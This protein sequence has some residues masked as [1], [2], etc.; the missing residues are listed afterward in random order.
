MDKCTY[1]S[2]KRIGVGQ[3]G[4]KGPIPVYHCLLL[5]SY[6]ILNND[7]VTVVQLDSGEESKEYLCCEVCIHN[8]S[9]AP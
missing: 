4:C 6:C 1:C 8:N 9:K 7:P 3:C 2:K 5:D